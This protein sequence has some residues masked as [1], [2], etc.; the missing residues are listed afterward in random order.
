MSAN[1]LKA[2][3]LAGLAATVPM[4][5]LMLLGYRFLLRSEEQYPLPPA[6]ITEQIVEAV[7]GEETP[8]A[9]AG[10]S[11]SYPDTPNPVPAA[12]AARSETGVAGTMPALTLAAHLGYGA[13]IGAA[14]GALPARM[15]GAALSPEAKGIVWGLAVWTTSYLGWLPLVHVLRPATEHPA[16][17]TALMIAAHVLWGAVAGRLTAQ[18]M[19]DGSDDEKE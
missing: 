1:N 10:A 4:T 11:Q 7:T 6:E 5:L 17:R 19:G 12:A 9:G 3:A 13:A 2:G 8:A 15:P 18:W 16:R 14:Y